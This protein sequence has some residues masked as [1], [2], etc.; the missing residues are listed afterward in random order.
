LFI[1]TGN[2]SGFGKTQIEIINAAERLGVK[3]VVKLSALG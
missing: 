2:H 3:Q 1:L